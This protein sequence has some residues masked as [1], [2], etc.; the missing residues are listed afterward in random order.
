WSTLDKRVD[1]AAAVLRDAGIGRGDAVGLL[2]YNAAEF[3]EVIVATNRVGAVFLP[4]NWRLAAEEVRY[5]LAHAQ[6]RGLV[7]AARFYHVLDPVRRTLD[8]IRLRLSLDATPPAGWRAYTPAV[9][10]QLKRGGHVADAEVGED[11]LHRLM[12]TSGTTAHPKGVMLSYANLYWKNLAHILEFGLSSADR[13]LIIGP[14]YHVGALDLPGTGMLH[15]G[16]APV[17]P[18]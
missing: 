8:G 2:L 7:S 4:L 11:D 10:E 14:L 12:Y 3:V 18:P 16:G 9:Q 6:A 1:A 17:V 5:I 13:T 15:A